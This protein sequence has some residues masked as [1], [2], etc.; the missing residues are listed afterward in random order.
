M[1][2]C[3][4]IVC[5]KYVSV[6]KIIEVL[7]DFGKNHGQKYLTLYCQ[8]VTKR[9]YIPKQTWIFQLQVCLSMY[10]RLLPPVIK[11]GA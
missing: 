9:S 2:Q 7:S 11:L 3:S 1:G 5:S 10:D 4:V 8:V 6:G